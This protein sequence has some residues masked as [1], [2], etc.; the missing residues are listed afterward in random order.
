MDG[1]PMPSSSMRLTRLA[2]EKRGGGWVKCWS[3]LTCCR[4]SGSR[5]CMG[6][7]MRLSS[8]ALLSGASSTS[9]R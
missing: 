2:S 6:G 7:S 3:A 9:S 8:A 1:R 5:S 4:A